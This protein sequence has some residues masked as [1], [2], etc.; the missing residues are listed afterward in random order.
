MDTSIVGLGSGGSERSKADGLHS[1]MTRGD[2]V[3]KK[4]RGI[5]HGTLYKMLCVEQALKKAERCASKPL[6]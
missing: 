4:K 5:S 1:S 2:S 3:G 6:S